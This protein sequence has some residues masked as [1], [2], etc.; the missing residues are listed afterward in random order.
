MNVFAPLFY[1]TGLTAVLANYA[2]AGFAILFAWTFSVGAHAPKYQL[3]AMGAALMLA[4]FF[5]DGLNLFRLL[6]CGLIFTPLLLATLFQQS[7]LFISRERKMFSET[8]T[9]EQAAEPAKTTRRD[10]PNLPLK[11]RPSLAK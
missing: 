5:L 10:E 6:N 1:L 11:S 8:V 9:E 7:L 4:S 2:D 3:P